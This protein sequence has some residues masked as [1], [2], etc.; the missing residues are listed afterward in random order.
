MRTDFKYFDDKIWEALAQ[1]VRTNKEN[2]H[3]MVFMS[4]I[5]GWVGKCLYMDCLYPRYQHLLVKEGAD[6]HRDSD[7]RRTVP[8]RKLHNL[9]QNRLAVLIRKGLVKTG[10]YRNKSGWRDYLYYRLATPTEIVEKKLASK[11]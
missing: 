10:R 4:D 11:Q 1:T 2:G 7:P 3:N 5:Y 6:I 8:M 9:I